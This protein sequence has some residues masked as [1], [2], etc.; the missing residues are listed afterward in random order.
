MLTAAH[1]IIS[2]KEKNKKECHR[3]CKT[4]GKVILIEHLRD[5]LNYLAF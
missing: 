2:N 5:L 4:S 1:K 3:V